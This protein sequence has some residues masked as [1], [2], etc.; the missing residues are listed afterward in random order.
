MPKIPPQL[1]QAVFYIYPSEDD[2]INNAEFGATGFF[3][4][5]N[6]ESLDGMYYYAVTNSHVIFQDGMEN[7]TIRV[8]T[9]ENKFDV[10][11][12]SQNNWVRHFAGDDIAICPIQIESDKIAGG[13]FTREFIANEDFLKKHAVGAGDDVFMIGRFR[14]HAGRS[15]NLPVVR[16][17]NIAA[18]N[19]EGLYNDATKLYQESYLVEMRS[20]AGFSGSPVFIYSPYANLSTLGT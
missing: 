1:T 20:I 11:K 15:R 16:F 6:S 2:A 5:V 12:T 8:N 18:M 9:T 10:I 19:D 3:F 17:G 14:V 4:G 13:C 7:P